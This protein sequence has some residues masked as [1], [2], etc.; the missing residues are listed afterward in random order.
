MSN[1]E[2]RAWIMVFVTVVAYGAY[3]AVVLSRSATRPLS[4]VDYVGPLLWSVG[5]S[6]LAGIILNIAVGVLSSR[7]AREKDERDREIYR[8]GEYIGQSFLVIGGVAALLLAIVEAPHFYIANALYLAFVLSA[9]LGSM[10]KIVA[11][12]RGFVGW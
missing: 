5:G 4:D 8:A 12:R 11:Y 9:L 1:E 10:A 6:I 2:K 3:V 7:G